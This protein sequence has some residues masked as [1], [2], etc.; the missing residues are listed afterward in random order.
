MRSRRTF[1]GTIVALK[2]EGYGAAYLDF[3]VGDGILDHS[4]DFAKKKDLFS[5]RQSPR[6]QLALLRKH[7]CALTHLS[8]HPNQAPSRVEAQGISHTPRYK[9]C[10]KGGRGSGSCSSVVPAGERRLSDLSRRYLRKV[11]AKGERSF[12]ID[13]GKLAED[14]LRR[15]LRLAHQCEGD[16][17]AGCVALSRSS[18]CR[19]PVALRSA[20]ARRRSSSEEH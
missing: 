2:D 14:A 8:A 17:S 11:G 16:P 3:R 15:D 10:T 7:A 19:G 18:L 12:E 5:T 1:I 13:A 6:L 20:R 4:V 9:V